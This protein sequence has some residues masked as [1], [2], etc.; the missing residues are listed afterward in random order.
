MISFNPQTPQVGTI[1]IHFINEPNNLM[2]GEHLWLAQGH[3]TEQV[4]ELK[5]EGKFFDFL[6]H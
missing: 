2:T 6:L 5:F 3:I 4:V 1:F